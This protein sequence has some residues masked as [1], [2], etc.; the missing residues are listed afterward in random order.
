MT[1]QIEISSLDLRFEGYRLK[2]QAAERALLASIASKGI[3]DPLQGADTE[4]SRIL[5][6]GFK[7]YRCAKK[8]KIG[9]VPYRPLAV[10][11]PLGI[12]ELIRIS[13]SRTL[14]IL[15]QAKLIDEL[16]TVYQMSTGDIADLLEK[17]KA[18]VSVR[19]GIMNDM[20]QT[21]MDHVFMGSFPV[22]AFIY[23]LR[24]F[25]RINKI[26]K[27][28]IDEFVNLTAG[29]GLSIRD[30]EVLARGFF[31]GSDEIRKQIKE[32]DFSWILNR[33]KESSA[34]DSHCTKIENEMLKELEIVQKY[35]QRAIYKSKDARYKTD[36]FLAQANLLTGGLLTMLKIFEQAMRNLHDRTR[37][38]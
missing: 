6:N 11:T 22:Y 33:L 19:T 36:A 31:K 17:S 38:T 28:Q 4:D 9:V 20:S 14:N 21:V 18:W 26:E 13:N 32:G 8:L 2:N 7:R 15:E 10:D 27:S 1:E 5:L 24:P 3:R 16:K 12:I 25:I 23:I 29:K 34:T 30:I 35:M 37:Q